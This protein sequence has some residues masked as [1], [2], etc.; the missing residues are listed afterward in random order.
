[1]I[2]PD[3][4]QEIQDALKEPDTYIMYISTVGDIRESVLAHYRGAQY[5]EPRPRVRLEIVVVNDLAV[6]ETIDMILHV[7]C[8]C[9]PDG[10]SNG[11]IFVMPLDQW[12]RIPADRPISV[13][14]PD[15]NT[16]PRREAS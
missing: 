10:V 15:E 14:N 6:Q 13:P 2:R 3:K 7:S 4:V 1:M 12:I 11:S 9:S 16:Y 5:R 8:S